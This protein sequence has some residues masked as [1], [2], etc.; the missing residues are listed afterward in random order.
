MDIRVRF[1]GGK[2]VD[3]RVGAHCVRTDQSVE[4]G[5]QGASPEPF[6]VFLAAL[7]SSS[8]LYV[9]TLCQARGLP[10]DEVWLEQHPVFD[11]TT[12]ALTQVTVDVHVPESFPDRYRDEL[13]RAAENNGLAKLLA[14]PPAIVVHSIRDPRPALPQAS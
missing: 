7:A 5:G 13:V 11:P 1:P 6:E 12:R 10:T 9:L 3:A 4:H 14:A 2:R 8:G